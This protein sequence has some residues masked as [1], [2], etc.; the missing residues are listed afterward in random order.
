MTKPPHWSRGPMLAV[1]A[2][3]LLPCLP[4]LA[5]DA[6]Q[7]P[8]EAHVPAA[9]APGG[10]PPAAA[11]AP[12]AAAPP[13]APGAWL[14]VTGDEETAAD[15]DAGASQGRVNELDDGTQKLL[16]AYRTATGETDSIKAYTEKLQAQV[17]SQRDDIASIERQLADVETTAREVLPLT[18]R[19]LD[20]LKSFV[21]LDVPFLIEERRNRIAKLEREMDRADVTLSEKFRRVVEAYQ[22]EM[23]YGRTME[24]YD[25]RLGDGPDA[26]TVQ[27][28]R[29][30]RTALL[31]QTLDGNE[32]GYWDTDGKNWVV[33]NDYRQ[34]FKRGLGVA[35]KLTAP[36]LIEAPVHAPKEAAS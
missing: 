1:A 2:L 5:Q 34:A 27:F 30:G 15:Q 3:L 24:A 11:A 25:G 12:A 33:D 20:T 17:N 35:K 14:E 32:T 9:A 36:D 8:P 23:E 28:L 4:S 22:I 16:A 29:I 31:Y 26:R 13:A 19:M 21:D 18:Q 6:A 10:A 7:D